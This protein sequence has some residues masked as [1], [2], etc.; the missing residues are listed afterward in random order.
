MPEGNGPPGLL[1]REREQ[2]ELDAAMSLALD[3]IPQVVVLAGDAGLGKTTLVADLARRAEGLGF[4]VA[5]GHCLDI[6]ADISFAP[7]VEAIRTLVEGLEGAESRPLARRMSSVLNPATPTIVEQ[8]KLLED[9]RL[10]VLEAAASGPVLLAI[11]DLHWADSST[12]DFAVALSRTA[13]ARLL[14]V[15]TVRSDDLH[16]RHPARKSLAEISRVPGGRRV[17]LGPLERN[18]IAGIVARVTGAPADPTVVRM[19]LERSEGNPLYAEELCAAGAGV[20]PGELSDL[21]LARLDA[22]SDGPRAL[23]RA[24]SVD[25]SQVDADLLAELVG[26]ERH[27][28]NSDL[29]SLLD[30][31][32]LRSVGESLQFRHGLVREAVY[33]DLLPDERAALHARLAAI[34]QARVDAAPDASL[35]VLSRLAFHWSAAHD[36]PRCLWSRPSEQGDER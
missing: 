24:A 10:T 25:G 20:I 5:V 14:L 19:T 27:Q 34:L 26:L 22:L 6:E 11:E 33:D 7:V 12:R 3:G 31:N 32:V 13:R 16:R 28:L 35:S 15:L 18:G 30:A 4:A 17:E 21:F 9:L 29:R 36:L 23:A 8:T 1:G 2:A